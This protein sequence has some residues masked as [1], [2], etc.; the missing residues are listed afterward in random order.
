MRVH[1]IAIG[2]SIMHNLA[3]ALS[4][5]GYIVSGSD[6]Y[7]YEPAHSNLFEHGLL[8]RENGWYPDKI[9]S[10]L[11]AVILGMHA[12][13]DN[14]ELI[15]AKELGIT[16]YSY[17][18]F[19]YEQSVNKL[20][21]VIGGSYGK[22]TITSM[23]MHVLKELGRE[24]DY[25]VGAKLNDF[26]N[27][28]RISKDAP[29]IIIEGDDNFASVEDKRPKFLLYKANIA[30]ISGIA[31]DHVD[32][33]PTFE[34]YLRQ[35]KLFIESIAP[36]GT[37]IY[38]KEDK[39]VQELVS[40]NNSRI[41]KHGYRTPEFT[42]N[43][44][45]T[46]VHTPEG[47]IPLQVFGRHNLSNLA[48]AYT[49]CEWLGISRKEFFR[50]IQSFKGASRRLEFVTSNS[51]SVVYKD[52]AHTPSK[53]KASIQA[54]KEQYPDKTLVAIMEL[55]SN[56]SLNEGFL[57]EYKDTMNKADIPLIFINQETFKQKN[58]VPLSDSLLRTAFNNENIV[59]FSTIHSLKRY[60]Q[61]IDS[62]GKNLLFMSS[63]NFGG[64]SLVNF[65][66]E[67]IS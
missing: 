22:T 14:P 49:V 47:E 53:V 28:V 33:Y 5:K 13:A 54:V 7:I 32:I 60:L 52:F 37:L 8:P 62:K 24:F 58:L 64:I 65:A 12:K 30:L 20:R 63:G 45:Q 61:G 56:V 27:M 6:D 25:V 42:I 66:E 1:F 19:I 21:V 50:I 9:D 17:P 31:W 29:I 40:E 43:K 15:K 44:G 67:F 26:E 11:D 57:S 38:N 34:S 46:S 10:E 4:N 48:A 3:I 59:C 18:E 2:G 16:V 41:N 39:Q 51:E 55:P 35:F 36:K 23:I